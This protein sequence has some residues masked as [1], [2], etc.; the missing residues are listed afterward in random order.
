MST[1]E[2]PCHSTHFVRTDVVADPMN[3][4]TVRREFTE[5]LGRHFTLDETKTSDVV[6]AVNEAMH[7]GVHARRIRLR[8]LTLFLLRG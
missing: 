8:T 5:W 4:A 6:L 3:A 7:L 1:S 2:Y